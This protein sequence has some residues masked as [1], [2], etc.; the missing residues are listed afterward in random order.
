MGVNKP[1]PPGILFANLDYLSVA[2]A[3]SSAR[4]AHSQPLCFLER[5]CLRLGFLE[6]EPQMGVRVYML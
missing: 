3:S 1:F 6:A 2:F 5:Q 4:A